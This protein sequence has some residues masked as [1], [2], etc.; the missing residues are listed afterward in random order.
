MASLMV[1]LSERWLMSLSGRCG[2]KTDRALR[3]AA[4]GRPHHDPALQANGGNVLAMPAFIARI[5]MTLAIS[6][7]RADRGQTALG[8]EQPESMKAL[9]S[10]RNSLLMPVSPPRCRKVRQSL[11]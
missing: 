3:G 2:S 10:T 9:W 1:S 6:I 8:P 5:V 11:A 4:S 7:S